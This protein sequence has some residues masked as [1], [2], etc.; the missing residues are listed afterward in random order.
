[1]LSGTPE[2]LM[3]TLLPAEEK[4]PSDIAGGRLESRGSSGSTPV[5]R[6]GPAESLEWSGSAKL[7]ILA[8]GGVTLE[9]GVLIGTGACVLRYLGSAK[10]RW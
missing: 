6:K 2:K 4:D 7:R 1:M 10:M 5:Q 3:F 8:P 9:D